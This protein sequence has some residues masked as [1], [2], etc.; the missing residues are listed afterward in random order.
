VLVIACVAL[1][2]C[3]APPALYPPSAPPDIREACALTERRC[4]ECHDRDRILDAHNKN[5]EDW[6]ATI[7][8][9]RQMPGSTIRPE[10]TETILHCLLYRTDTS[11]LQLRG[12]HTALLA[13]WI[14]L[15]H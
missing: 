4:T 3:Q 5:R 15:A 6:D 10:E 13:S 9:M 12:E 2:A 8:R 7:E 1:V 11:G 14:D